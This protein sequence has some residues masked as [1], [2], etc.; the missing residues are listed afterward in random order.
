[1]TI[2]D[3]FGNVIVHWI[4]ADRSL[5]F[6]DAKYGQHFQGFSLA[7]SLYGEFC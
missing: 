6:L 5:L 4:H 2:S 7:A 3:Y 1:M